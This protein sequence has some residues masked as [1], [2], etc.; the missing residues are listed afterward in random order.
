MKFLFAQIILGVFLF[1]ALEAKADTLKGF[2]VCRDSEQFR[3]ALIGS[4]GSVLIEFDE[5][6]N[7]TCRKA[8]DSKAWLTCYGLQ[9]TDNKS[10]EIAVF[11]DSEGLW[12]KY[13]W[14]IQRNTGMIFQGSVPNPEGTVQLSCQVKN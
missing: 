13:H 8:V 10:I 7:L 4:T 1:S 3:K 12:A 9:I 2:L 14:V 6:T 5:K 11:N